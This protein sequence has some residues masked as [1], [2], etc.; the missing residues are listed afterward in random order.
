[1]KKIYACFCT[2]VIHE[3]HLNIIREAGRYG[4]VIAGVL[5]DAAMIRY[6]RFPTVTFEERKRMLEEIPQIS[7]VVV[8]QEVLYET[9]LERLRPDFV[10][11]GDNW[12]KG[13]MRI[14]R[15]NVL[16]CLEKWGGKLIEIPYTYSEK[17]RNTEA[18]LRERTGMP[19]YRRKR[20]R[21][22]LRLCGK[23][24]GSTQRSDRPDRGKDDGIAQWRDRSV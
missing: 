18:L 11:H 22:L 12:T 17:I 5:G 15:D 14:I 9:I 24:T 4:E 19:E 1:M 6:N 2:D 13:P 23:G 20:L 7:Q 16:E 21:M 3:G 10:I 8:Q